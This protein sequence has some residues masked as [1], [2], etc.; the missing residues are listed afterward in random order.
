MVS[1]T[2]SWRLIC[3]CTRF[4]QVGARESSKSAM[5]TFAPELRAL[6]TIFRSV[7]PV[8]STRRSERSAGLG[9]TFQS[10]LRISTVLGRKF[11]NSPL[12]SCSCLTLRF[13]R[14]SSLVF[15]KCLSNSATNFRAS[16]DKTR[17]EPSIVYPRT[18][19]PLSSLDD[20]T[21]SISLLPKVDIF[22][23]DGLLFHY[24]LMI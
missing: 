11:G 5:K 2:A 13:K 18:S 17:S 24:F 10:P 3:P 8:I 9:P 1:L 22:V 12:S 23:Y 20:I 21:F 16:F 6:I 15:R 14:S 7:G 19:I 4:S